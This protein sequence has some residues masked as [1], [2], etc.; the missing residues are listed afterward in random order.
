[1]RKLLKCLTIQYL[2]TVNECE[3]LEETALAFGIPLSNFVRF[4]FIL[5]AYICVQ[6]VIDYSSPFANIEL[7]LVS[8]T[9]CL[10]N[11]LI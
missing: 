2:A 1:V 9:S 7:S 8:D 4:E 6:S 5:S 11:K 10:L 3:W